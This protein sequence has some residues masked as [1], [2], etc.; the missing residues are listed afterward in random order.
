MDFLLSLLIAGASVGSVY[1]L[2]AVGLNFTFWT[3]R[4]LNF[5][6]GAVMMIC[7]IA[8]AMLASR[9]MGLWS[10]ALVAIT[11][12]AGVGV[13]VERLAVRPAL[14]AAGSLGWVISTL[15]FGI[16][17]QG[18][19]AKLFGSQ[20]LPFPELLFRA[21]DVVSVGGQPLSLQYAAIFVVSVTII[22][23][24]ELLMRRTVM[25]SAV[26]AV[27]QDAELGEVQGLPV[28]WI[29]SGSF[30]ASSV[31]AGVAGILVAQIGGTIDPAFGFEL[32]LFGFVAAVV[33]G[34]G[35]SAGALVGGIGVG[36]LSKL[37]GG[38]VS[39]AA[40]HGIAF[41]VLVLMLAMRPQGLF[42]RAEVMKA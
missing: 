12:V 13:M 19:A 34:M 37:V 16:L 36:I 8:T 30:V 14:K 15:G 24:L 32:V 2:V 39:T 17:L 22:G 42:G 29:V 21:S 10:S 9:G 27:A 7:A 41:A 5:G 35:S 4:T 3:T 38:Y 6:Q 20:A 25:G 23:A 40:E 18:I 1:A 28:K 26:R 33:G 11:I 31:L